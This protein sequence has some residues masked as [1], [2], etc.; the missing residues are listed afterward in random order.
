M[1]QNGE[2]KRRLNSFDFMSVRRILRYRWHD[3]RS[4]NLVLRGWAETS[5]RIVRE[6]QLRIYGHAARHPSKDPAQWIF[7]VEIR[8][9]EPC[10]GG[11]LRLLDC[12]R[13]SIISGL[14]TAW[15]WKTKICKTEAGIRLRSTRGD[16]LHR[17]MPPYL[18]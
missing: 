8:A 6:P 16:A 10:R 11:S 15:R 9:P 14:A 13:W 2:L 7:L 5:H 3:Y 12:V 1:T 4:D 17:R 18:T